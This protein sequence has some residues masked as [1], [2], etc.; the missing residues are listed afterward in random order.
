MWR[1]ELFLCVA[2]TAVVCACAAGSDDGVREVKTTQ[3]VVRGH[4][5]P[6]SGVFA[7]YSIPYATLP[8]GSQRFK[9]SFQSISVFICSF[10]NKK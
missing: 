7:F 10:N 9:V 3:G 4:K 2:V 5:D 8:I 6:D 1:R